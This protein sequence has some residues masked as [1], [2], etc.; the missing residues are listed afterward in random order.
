MGCGPFNTRVL[1]F[2]PPFSNGMVA[3]LVIGQTD[4][5]HN[6][7]AMSQTGLKDPVGLGFDSVG[8]MWVADIKNNGGLMFP[9][10][11]G[12]S[13]FLLE[14]QAGWNLISLPLRPARTAIAKLLRR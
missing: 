10:S 12:L 8:N 13:R 6:G 7:G 9:G 3:N 2:A 4:F 1:I 5:A 14:L 11:T